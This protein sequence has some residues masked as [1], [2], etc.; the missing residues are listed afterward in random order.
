MSSLDV[1]KEIFS[2]V[3][4][5][6]GIISNKK[7]SG[8]LYSKIKIKPV[9]IK[10][11]KVFQFE[12]FGEKQ[13]FHKNFSEFEAADEVYRLMEL[14]KQGEFFC[15][16]NDVHILSS[17]RNKVKISKKRPS[18][19]LPDNYMGHNRKKKYILNDGEYCDFLF[20]LGIM[21]SEGKVKSK[22]YD[23]F[24]QI[25][26]YLEIVS[27]CISK[28]NGGETIR[29]VDFGCGKAYLTFALYYYFVKILKYDVE[30]VGLD[31]KEGVIEKCNSIAKELG[32][33]KLIF[34]IGDI[35][36]YNSNEKIHMVISLH[37]CDTA[38]DWS[39]AKAIS[40]GADVI[41]AVPCCQHEFFPKI[42]NANMNIV[43]RHGIL[44][45]RMAAILTDG[46]RANVMEIMAYK[47]DIFEFIDMEHTPKN[48]V[49]R[50]FKRGTIS[51]RDIVEYNDFKKYWNINPE[52][53]EIVGEEF[54]TIVNK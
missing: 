2:D 37:A 43:E 38:T 50:G 9:L 46:L 12:Y 11:S 17:K 20:F 26:R 49:I 48:L 44:K 6:E 34:K 45:E 7:K 47:T 1:L 15:S 35:K 10:G 5:I 27:D 32:Y 54:K 13:V 30:I 52:I 28:L 22:K 39:I 25:N 41:L 14:Y 4:F 19:K 23:K 53:E 51:Q 16:E 40:W 3:I 42:H 29:I 36:E 18:K 8:E 24:K 21:N 33:E 31:L